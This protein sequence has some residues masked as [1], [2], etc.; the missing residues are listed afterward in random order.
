MAHKT[1]LESSLAV[2]VRKVYAG[3]PSSVLHAYVASMQKAA[4]S[5]AILLKLLILCA[6]DVILMQEQIK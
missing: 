5:K 4:S 3:I 6:H 2:C 1:I